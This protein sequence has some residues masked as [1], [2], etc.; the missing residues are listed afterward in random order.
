MSWIPKNASPISKGRKISPA[1]CN[2]CNLLWYPFI[3]HLIYL[4]M[5]YQIG[6]HFVGSCERSLSWWQEVWWPLEFFKHGISTSPPYTPVLLGGWWASPAPFMTGAV[7]GHSH[8]GVFFPDGFIKFPWT[9][10]GNTLHLGSCLLFCDFPS[11]GLPLWMTLY[12]SQSVTASTLDVFREKDS[13]YGVPGR[14]CIDV[15]AYMCLPCFRHINGA[16]QPEEENSMPIIFPGAIQSLTQYGIS[17]V[18]IQAVCNILTEYV[19]GGWTT[20]NQKLSLHVANA[21]SL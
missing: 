12:S 16:T 7:S 3:C 11:P 20:E 6:R 5:N 19:F 17:F 1:F 9:V 14:F 8:P 18:T 21:I 4:E 13:Y 15:W 2:S 10:D